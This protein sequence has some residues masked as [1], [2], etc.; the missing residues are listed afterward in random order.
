MYRREFLLTGPAGTPFLPSAF[1]R[2]DPDGSV[3]IMVARA[4]MGQGSRTALALLVAEELDAEC[5]GCST[6]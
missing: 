2:I 4:E 3:T 5:R 6:R 1:L